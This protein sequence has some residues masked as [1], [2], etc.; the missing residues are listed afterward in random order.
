MKTLTA[1]R[2]RVV[3]IEQYND[4]PT[5]VYSRTLHDRNPYTRSSITP[6]HSIA[7]A[8][9]WTPIQWAFFIAY[10]FAV[11]SLIAIIFLERNT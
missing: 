10:T 9:R 5:A 11:I 2:C 8:V 6:V 4:S 1:A 3:A 7:E